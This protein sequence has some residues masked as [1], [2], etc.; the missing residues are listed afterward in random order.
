[1]GPLAA[2][3]GIVLVVLAPTA[4]SRVAVLVFAITTVVLFTVSAIYHRGTWS[5]R[6]FAILRRLDHS[7]IFLVIAGTRKMLEWSSRRRIAKWR[8]DHV[9][10]RDPAP[11]GPF[12]HLPGDRRDLH[13]ARGHSLA[14]EYR[15]DLAHRGVGRSVG[16]NR[17][18]GV[19]ATRPALVLRARL[20]RP[21]LGGGL[22]P[23]RVPPGLEFGRGVVDHRR[24]AGLHARG[25]R[26]RVQVA[27]S[28]PAILRV[29][30]DLPRRHRDRLRL[31]RG[32]RATGSSRVALSGGHRRSRPVR[33]A[34][35]KSPGQ[36]GTTRYRR[37]RRLGTR[38]RAVRT[39][40][41]SSSACSVRCSSAPA[42]ARTTP[43]GSMMA[44]C[45]LRPGPG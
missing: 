39:T 22:V 16:R 33:R 43:V 10:L 31:S 24:R 29:P 13:P 38:V 20:Y 6:H 37:W 32:C 26:L 8:G 19:L 2:V 40:C 5:P 25:G 27:E 28:Q 45:P 1:M 4:S 34:P 21:R 42:W 41:G 44:L 12:Q 18:A 17:C 36:A 23:A 30:R 35:A 9:P 7:N 11:A 14:G 15:G 3:M